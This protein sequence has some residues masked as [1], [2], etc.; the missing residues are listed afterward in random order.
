[1]NLKVWPISAHFVR[2]LH[3][4]APFAEIAGKFNFDKPT[5]TIR[6]INKDHNRVG[7]STVILNGW[8]DRPPK[9]LSSKLVFACLR[10]TKSDYAQLICKDQ[11]TAEKLASRKPEDVVSVVG[12]VQPKKSKD[13]QPETWELVLKDL[14][15][16]NSADIQTVQLNSLKHTTGQF[17]Q[18]F[19][20]L[21]LRQPYYQRSLRKRAQIAAVA[22][23]V[24]DANEFVEIETPLLFKST[25]EGADEFL[26]PTRKQGQFYA[27]PQS[28]QQYKQLLM[29]SGF[30]RYY[31]LAKCF[32]DEDLRADR[33]PEFTQIDLEMSFAKKEDVMH[34][35]ETVIKAIFKETRQADLFTPSED[36]SSLV[37]S[38]E[39]PFKRLSYREAMH[40]YGIDKPD[41]RSNLRFKLLNEFYD[42]QGSVQGVVLPGAANLDGIDQLIS[43]HEYS[44]RR[45]YIAKIKSMNDL[46]TWHSAS[47]FV[48]KGNINEL[49]E[50][51]GLQV[52]DVVA[53][54]DLVYPDKERHRHVYE[55]PTPLGKFR[56]LAIQHFPDL[57][58]YDTG[59]STNDTFAACW[60]TNFP[61]FSPTEDPLSKGKEYPV[62]LKDTYEATH[63]P[64]TMFDLTQGVTPSLDNVLDVEGEHYDLVI[65]GVEVGGGS[66][67]IH[68]AQVQRY[69]LKEIL[70]VHNAEE[71]FG[72]L[73]KA[74]DSG[75]PP[76]AGFAVGFDRLCSMIVGS[77]NIRDVVAFPKTQAGTDPV[78]GSPS[79]V[80]QDTLD[81]YHI[82]C[83]DV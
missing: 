49:N 23:R 58:R 35:V 9:K 60:V 21:Q 80:A 69:V 1:M 52:G 66:Q 24:L 57:W 40:Y 76:H 61:L 4:L 8:I 73:L 41:L 42:S 74:L 20:Y 36:M 64:F 7:Q 27:L 45:P 48:F 46:T 65:N 38:G 56:Q 3:N 72:H 55:N 50:S 28:P 31:Q 59:Q 32:R 39:K 14:K 15:V 22:R 19:R 11:E 43:S 26:V 13:G 79:R 44:N 81:N 12:T 83:K 5:H 70:K 77:S 51:L 18:E 68:D 53:L 10:D 6:E 63:H 17:P 2:S 33:Q 54:G 67:R 71:L 16:L 37:L 30:D 29:A 75:C 25:P 62:Y 78:V 82:Q 47:P 34:T